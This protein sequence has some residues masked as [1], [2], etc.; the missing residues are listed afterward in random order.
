MAPHRV[1]ASRSI[2]PGAGCG[3]W[4]TNARFSSFD[5]SDVRSARAWAMWIWSHISS[6]VR[7]SRVIPAKRVEIAEGFQH[8]VFV[9][10]Q[11]DLQHGLFDVVGER[12][13]RTV[14]PGASRG[15]I[16]RADAAPG[17]FRETMAFLPCPP[18][19][20]TTSNCQSRNWANQVAESDSIGSGLPYLGGTGL[21][22]VLPGV[23][24][25]ARNCHGPLDGVVPQGTEETR[26][27]PWHMVLPS[28]DEMSASATGS[29]VACIWGWSRGLPKAPGSPGGPELS[30]RPFRP[31][32]VQQ[33]PQKTARASPWHTVRDL[34]GPRGA[35]ARCQCHR[36]P[37]RC[38][39]VARACPCSSERFLRPRIAKAL[40]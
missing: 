23:P 17:R 16:E 34:A 36:P 3:G 12:A 22:G 21:P 14:P 11:Q 9:G 37:G 32:H 33:G 7:C 13:P 2:T 39:W 20:P 35:L 15:A 6:Q 31:A 40:G 8:Q 10:G 30:Q 26:A 19:C 27:S 38:I 28:A 1:A 24:L 18:S 25:A 29:P 5:A 4:S